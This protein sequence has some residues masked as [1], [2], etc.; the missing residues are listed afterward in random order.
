VKH[1]LRHGRYGCTNREDSDQDT[2]LRHAY[3]GLRTHACFSV[4]STCR[5]RRVRVCTRECVGAHAG[6][7]ACV[8]CSVLVLG[9][10]GIPECC[11]ATASASGSLLLV[12]V[13]ACPDRVRRV[14]RTLD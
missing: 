4:Y 1:G 6:L 11:M 9:N 8:V 10:V 13:W 7:A 14:C 12:D 2:C 3:G 5:P